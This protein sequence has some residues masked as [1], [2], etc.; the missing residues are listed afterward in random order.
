MAVVLGIR[1]P[2]CLLVGAV[3]ILLSQGRGGVLISIY[4]TWELGGGGSDLQAQL[5]QHLLMADVLG[6]RPPICLLVG[7]FFLFYL[8]RGKGGGRGGGG[9]SPSSLIGTWGLGGWKVWLPGTA[10]EAS[11]MAYIDKSNGSSCLGAG[12]GW[13][14]NVCTLCITLPT[15]LF[16]QYVTTYLAEV[17]NFV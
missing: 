5:E 3:F 4:I 11:M 14:G 6:I 12:G 2:I 13:G 15:H 17:L 1:P 10:G 8:A 9:W 7:V 16:L